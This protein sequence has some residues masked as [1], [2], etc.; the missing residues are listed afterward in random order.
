[1]NYAGDIRT[2]LRFERRTYTI[3]WSCLLQASKKEGN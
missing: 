1:L 3:R 2:W